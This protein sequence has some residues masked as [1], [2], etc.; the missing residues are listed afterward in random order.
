MNSSHIDAREREQ[1]L[2]KQKN[3]KTILQ[4]NKRMFGSLVSTL[5]KFRQEEMKRGDSVKRVE[6]ENKLD[7]AAEE[8]REAVNKEKG[9][10]FR[11]RKQKLIQLKYYEKKME[12]IKL[13]IY[14]VLLHIFQ[15]INH[16]LPQQHKK[17][18]DSQKTL[19]NFIETKAKPHVFYLP[20]KHNEA[21]S[22]RLQ[23]TKDKYRSK[24]SMIVNFNFLICFLF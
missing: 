18:E 13:V 17:W 14:I 6:I 12:I 3:N 8:E 11:E 22:K 15:I 19:N 20:V 16:L 10:L 23:E 2:E 21:S 24:S 1:V 7:K 5:E 9:K 4:R